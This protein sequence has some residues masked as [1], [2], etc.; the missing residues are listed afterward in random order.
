MNP[1]Y[2]PQTNPFSENAPEEAPVPGSETVQKGKMGRKQLFLLLGGFAFL[3]GVAI[4]GFLG[5][6][7]TSDSAR[8]PGNVSDRVASSLAP[9]EA[10]PHGLDAREKYD[11][12]G[13]DGASL[14]P[15]TTAA[16][17]RQAASGTQ[18]LT[19]KDP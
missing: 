5:G 10:R 2:E 13:S 6:F 14:N 1:D 15:T 4:F 3:L 9:P 11:K 7:I 8:K 12:Y 16:I 17:D 19:G 18:L